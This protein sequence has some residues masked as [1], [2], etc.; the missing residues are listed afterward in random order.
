M[1]VRRLKAQFQDAGA[2]TKA[3][4]MAIVCKMVHCGDGVRG[5]ELR[6]ESSINDCWFF[7]QELRL[8]SGRQSALVRALWSPEM[9]W[10]MSWGS[11]WEF[12]LR[13]H[14]TRGVLLSS[15]QESK[16]LGVRAA[17]GAGKPAWDYRASK[18]SWNSNSKQRVLL[19]PHGLHDIPYLAGDGGLCLSWFSL[20]I[21]FSFPL[22][23]P[24]FHFPVHPFI[25]SS[26]YSAISDYT[27]SR[28]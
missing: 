21:L 9:R 5:R 10:E 2:C 11:S 1:S 13:L 22:P 12:G 15:W 27:V 3:V 19:W 14:G 23:F 6:Q 18:R 24:L 26:I 8:C 4:M 7:L 17:L 20:S 16:G 25:L 28:A